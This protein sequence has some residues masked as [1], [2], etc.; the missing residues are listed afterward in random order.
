MTAS[1]AV[2]EPE[3]FAEMWQALNDIIADI[4][5]RLCGDV[6]DDGGRDEWILAL[7]G[8]RRQAFG[9]DDWGGTLLDAVCPDV[10]EPT[11]IMRKKPTGALEIW[12]EELRLGKRKA[13]TF[14]ALRR[15]AGYECAG[16]EFLH[17]GLALAAQ[18]AFDS[19]DHVIREAMKRKSRRVA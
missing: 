5:A 19:A 3:L 7:Y 15:A 12:C 16:L 2:S 18:V 8:G 4:D 13:T 6:D 17:Q 10:D 11:P 1:L 9:V 14:D